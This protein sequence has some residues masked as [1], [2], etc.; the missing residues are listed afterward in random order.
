MP[1]ERRRSVKNLS[2]NVF[3]VKKKSRTILTLLVLFIFLGSATIAVE[4]ASAASSSK[5]FQ[6]RLAS[7]MPP[8]HHMHTQIWDWWANEVNKRTN[9]R[10]KVNIYAAGALGNQGV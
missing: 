8:K 7:P 3:Y 4:T 5:K 2:L 10:V 1:N 6:L 9:G